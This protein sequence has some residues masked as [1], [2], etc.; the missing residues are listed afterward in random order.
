MNR[1]FVAILLILAIGLQG[2][3]LAYAAA[4]TAKTMPTG[5]ASYMLSQDGHDNASCCPD[6]I[7]AGLCCSAGVVFGGVPSLL[8]TRI[9]SPARLLP[10]D[11]GAV[12]LATERPSPPLRPPIS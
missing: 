1:R 12:T 11:S 9:S 7:G 5:C 6:N 2:P 10:P 4:L 8:L 3:S